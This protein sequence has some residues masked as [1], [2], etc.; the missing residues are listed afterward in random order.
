MEKIKLDMK[1]PKFRLKLPKFQRENEEDLRIG[2]YTAIIYTFLCSLFY[3]LF[4][5]S[6]MDITAGIMVLSGMVFFLI[7]CIHLFEFYKFKHE[8]NKSVHNSGIF[9]VTILMTA[10]AFLMIVG[11][12]IVF[13]QTFIPDYL[14]IIIGLAIFIPMFSWWEILHAKVKR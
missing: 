1:K 5:F 8:K 14:E 3:V 12:G 2:V 10:S 13:V 4:K 9:F 11:Q 7:M 6:G